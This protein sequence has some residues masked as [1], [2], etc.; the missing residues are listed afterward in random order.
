MIRII[1]IHRITSY[2]SAA[3]SP[4]YSCDLV[5]RQMSQELEMSEQPGN[6]HPPDT[7]IV[8]HSKSRLCLVSKDKLSFG[9][10]ESSSTMEPQSSIGSLDVRRGESIGVVH[11]D[12]HQWRH[13]ANNHQGNFWE[14]AANFVSCRCNG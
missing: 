5:P 12:D 13:M 8:L 10:K 6:E 14:A 2:S 1:V 11:N 7:R 3:K 4:P 9:D